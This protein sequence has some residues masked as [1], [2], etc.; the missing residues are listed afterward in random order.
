LIDLGAIFCIFLNRIH[1]RLQSLPTST[2]MSAAFR[3]AFISWILSHILT[4]LSMTTM[5][6]QQFT[7][8]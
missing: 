3:S 5:Y 4:R 6:K 1:S 2:N 7:H 8:H